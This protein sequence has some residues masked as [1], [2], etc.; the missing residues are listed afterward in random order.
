MGINTLYLDAEKQLAELLGW[1]D[2]HLNKLE[3][4]W[5]GCLVNEQIISRVPSWTKDDAASFSLMIRYRVSLE[6]TKHIVFAST[7]DQE[8]IIVNYSVHSDEA[9]AVRYAITMAVI[10]KLQNNFRLM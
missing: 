9:T 8:R 4:G 7:T 6:L 10:Q 1:K 2:I 5:E 3:N